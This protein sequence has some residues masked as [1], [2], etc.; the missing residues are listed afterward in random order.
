VSTAAAG[1]KRLQ[2]REP[3]ALLVADADLPARDLAGGCVG[4]GVWRTQI[5]FDRRG[6]SGLEVPPPDAKPPLHCRLFDGFVGTPPTKS[7]VNPSASFC[8]M[9]ITGALWFRD[10]AIAAPVLRAQ[11]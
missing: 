6:Q 7:R 10:W 4:A 1:Q 11:K 2:L 3:K 9:R 8:G 5:F